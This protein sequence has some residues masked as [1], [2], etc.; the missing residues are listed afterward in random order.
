MFVSLQ[1]TPFALLM[2]GVRLRAG[3]PGAASTAADTKTPPPPV[4]PHWIDFLNDDADSA[5]R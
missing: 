1:K 3:L 2:R 5:S 4:V